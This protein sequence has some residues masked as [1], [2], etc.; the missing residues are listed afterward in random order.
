MSGAKGTRHPLPRSR[1]ARHGEIPERDE[2]Q[3][4]EGSDP[5]EPVQP[6]ADAVDPRGRSYPVYDQARKGARAS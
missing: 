3:K 4:G 6:A 5:A 1:E 2:Q